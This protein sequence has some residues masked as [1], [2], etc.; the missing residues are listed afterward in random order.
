MSWI[1][2]DLILSQCCCC[3]PL[4]TGTIVIGILDIFGGFMSLLGGIIIMISDGDLLPNVLSLGIG[5]MLGILVA[6]EGAALLFAVVK[7]NQVAMVV[8]IVLSIILI[9]IY[10]IN[11]VLFLALGIHG[12]AYGYGCFALFVIV[13]VTKGYFL[14][15]VLGKYEQMKSTE[16]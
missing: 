10:M 14:L 8:H 3:I 1:Y 11:S 5:I 7:S 13:A 16:D 12:F 6:T 9:V 4:H 15:C 2:Q